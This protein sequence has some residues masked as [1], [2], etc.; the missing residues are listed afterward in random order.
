MSSRLILLWFLVL[1]VT[2]ADPMA[3][4]QFREVSRESGI[5]FQHTFG[6][7]ELSCIVEDT[8]AGVAWIDYDKDLYP[9]LLFVNATYLSGVNQLLPGE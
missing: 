3:D 2:Q 8:S 7:R 4:L 1:G 9:D 6:D 5:E